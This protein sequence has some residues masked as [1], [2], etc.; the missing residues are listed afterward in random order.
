MWDPVAGT[1]SPIPVFETKGDRTII[2]LPLGDTGSAFVVF[3][4]PAP[5]TFATAITAPSGADIFFN[6]SG[7]LLSQAGGSYRIRM[8]HGKEHA[9]EVA[10]SSAVIAVTAP[11]SVTFQPMFRE[12][13]TRTLDKL[14]S[15]SDSDDEVVKY[16]SGTGTYRT[17]VNVSQGVLKSN[18]RA[19]LDLG[20]V[21]DVANVRVNGKPAGTRWMPP[22]AVDVTPLLKAGDNMIEVDVTNRWVNRLM[23]DAKFPQDI[24]YQNKPTKKP[25]W[26]IIESYPDWLGDPAKIKSRQ[27][28]TFMS[29]STIYGPDDKL[30]ASG[31]IGPVQIRFETVTPFST[32]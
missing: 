20:A 18:Q 2:D 28:S 13:F 15:W 32:K 14:Q 8:S 17:T 10:Q 5:K 1:I 16:F 26:G 19:V 11:W 22:F 21:N 31:L 24:V 7:E 6:E 25:S 23:G 4:R 12:S 9:L 29:Y 3:R 27:R 30:P